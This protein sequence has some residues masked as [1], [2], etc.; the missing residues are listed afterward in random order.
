MRSFTAREP[1]EATHLG[2]MRDV[3]DLRIRKYICV[4]PCGL[5]TLAVE[6]ETRR[7]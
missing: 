3:E 7:N 6:P 4:E 2:V 1:N 5:F